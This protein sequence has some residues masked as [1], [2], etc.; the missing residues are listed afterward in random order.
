MTGACRPP[1]LRWA[2]IIAVGSEL[3]V[4]PRLDTNSLFITE[5]LNEYGIEV[6]AKAIVGDRRE[7]LEAVVRA[8]LARTE[9]VVLC[10]GLGP[11]DDD[12]TRDA[13]SAVTGRPLREQAG[14]LDGIRQRF[15]A[16]GARMPDI[17]RRQAMVPEGADVIPNGFGTAPGLW[18]EHAG[19]V[20]ERLSALMSGKTSL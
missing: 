18:L 16:R 13:V 19:R 12:L 8:A 11:T 3:L 4:P 5:R 9:L 20:L 6:R 7:D 2:E 15:A 14:V 1:A 10:G 17:N